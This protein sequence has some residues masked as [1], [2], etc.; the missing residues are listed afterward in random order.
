M[1]TEKYVIEVLPVYR[2][3]HATAN[4][5]LFIVKRQSDLKIK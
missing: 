2:D 5:N 4:Q 3:L 1:I